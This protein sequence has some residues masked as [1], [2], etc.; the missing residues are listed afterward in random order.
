MNSMKGENMTLLKN[1]Y[2]VVILSAILTCGQVFAQDI[3][4][5]YSGPLSG[6]AAEY[7]QDAFNGIE[8]AVNEINA[9]GGVIVD[10]KKHRFKLERL[11]DRADP[12]QA[13][14]NARRFRASG[15]IAVFNPVYNTAAAMMKFNQDAGNEFLVM[16]FTSTPRITDAGNKLL[17]VAPGSFN[18]MAEIS[19]R[20][21]IEKGWKKCA[22]LVTLG[23]YGDEWRNVFRTIWE[24]KGGVITADKPANYYTETDY[25]ASIT[26][27]LATGPEVLLIGGPSGTTALMIEQ[28]RQMGFKGGFILIDQASIDYIVNVLKS[29]KLLG[30]L[31]GSP[32]AAI[33]SPQGQLVAA[34][35]RESY[36]RPANPVCTFNFAFVHALARAISA[37]GTTSDVHKIR[38]AF[39]K[40][41]PMLIDEFPMEAYGVTPAGRFLVTTGTQTIT[42]GK[43]DKPEI[44]FWWPKTQKEY[45]E[46]EKMARIDRSIPRKW[47]Q[48]R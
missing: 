23:P 22:M 18:S 2:T 47:L 44:Y 17:L 7:G 33:P 34:R 1:I 8:L 30:D 15:A 38:Q 28:C 16:A 12:T 46:V 27:G 5:G 41:F 43:M 42:N 37:A 40:A 11:D 21:A 6:L 4:I 25:S 29:P 26:A 39:P 19:A 14:N 36:K 31:I 3:V 10:G 24:K 9:K 32:G 35:Y 48:T 45:E 13:A 20:W